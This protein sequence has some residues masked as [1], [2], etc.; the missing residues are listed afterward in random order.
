MMCKSGS[1]RREGD[2]WQRLYIQQPSA[3]CTIDWTMRN[4]S[5]VTCLVVCS[6]SG[7]LYKSIELQGMA[8]KIAAECRALI[9]PMQLERIEGWAFTAES[10]LIGGQHM[11]E[12]EN[13]CRPQRRHVGLCEARNSYRSL[14]THTNA[15]PYLLHER[16]W[17]LGHRRKEEIAAYDLPIYDMPVP[18][19]RVSDSR[20]SPTSMSMSWKHDGWNSGGTRKSELNHLSRTSD[21]LPAG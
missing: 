1:D 8:N 18:W 20:H 13:F 17:M 11:R 15:W 3:G 12:Y 5:L 7:F 14:W 9:L 2:S 10:S 6:I 19:S 21:G 16:D 4:T